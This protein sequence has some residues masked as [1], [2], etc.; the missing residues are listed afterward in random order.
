MEL[1]YE[2][3]SIEALVGLDNSL[4]SHDAPETHIVSESAGELTQSSKRKK[5]LPLR[6]YLLSEGFPAIDVNW[7][8]LQSLSSKEEWDMAEEIWKFSEIYNVTFIFRY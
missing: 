6:C 8:K 2:E 5:K 3:D 1:L 4:E 7:L